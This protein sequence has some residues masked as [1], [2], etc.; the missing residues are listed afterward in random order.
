MHKV[1]ITAVWSKI[2]AFTLKVSIVLIVGWLS[3]SIY[4]WMNTAKVD[5]QGSLQKDSVA[6]LT[7]HHLEKKFYDSKSLLHKAFAEGKSVV[8]KALHENK[9]IFNIILVVILL[10]LGR[11]TF[12]LADYIS[13]KIS[14]LMQSLLNCLKKYFKGSS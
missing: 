3:I 4:F 9:L 14:R 2:I 11:L 7:Y 10:F 1:N 13:E 6:H 8:Q 12:N 5:S